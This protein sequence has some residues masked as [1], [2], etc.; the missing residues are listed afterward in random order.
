MKHDNLSKGKGNLP[1]WFYYFFKVFFLPCFLMSELPGFGKTEAH[2]VS[3]AALEL[4]MSSQWVFSKFCRSLQL[5][6]LEAQRSFCSPPGSRLQQA[7]LFQPKLIKKPILLHCTGWT[8]IVE[9]GSAAQ[10]SCAFCLHGFLGQKAVPR[11]PR[12][13]ENGES[14]VEVWGGLCWQL[15]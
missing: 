6:L 9:R 2:Y 5:W 7:V 3:G 15:W 4:Q 12:E 11:A 13:L 1:S 10:C 14:H 8:Q